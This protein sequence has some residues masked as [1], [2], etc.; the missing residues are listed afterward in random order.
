MESMTFKEFLDIKHPVIKHEGTKIGTIN[1][2][3]QKE[4]AKQLKTKTITEVA[5]EMDI[6]YNWV[7]RVYDRY[8]R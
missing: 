4:I 5:K 3:K 7:W 1:V 2:D 8:C 6:K